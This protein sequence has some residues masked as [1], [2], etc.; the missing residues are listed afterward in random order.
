MQLYSGGDLKKATHSRLSSML[1]EMSA[2]G[3]EVC[4][5]VEVV[6]DYVIEGVG[7][8]GLAGHHYVFKFYSRRNRRALEM[9]I[10]EG[11]FQ[12]HHI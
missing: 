12:W 9:T 5:T 2:L 10:L 3:E 8:L 7:H 6:G 4:R 1:A 11:W